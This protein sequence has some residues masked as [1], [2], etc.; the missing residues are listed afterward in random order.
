MVPVCTRFL[1]LTAILLVL[2]TTS[3]FT[4]PSTTSSLQQRSTIIAL[5]TNPRPQQLQR[6]YSSPESTNKNDDILDYS[7]LP[8]KFV[9]ILAVK[10][11]KDLVN[12][13]P[14]LLEE[15]LKETSEKNETNPLVLLAKLMGVLVFKL[16]HDATHYPIVWSKRWAE[17]QSLEECPVDYPEDE[18]NN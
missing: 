7:L 17:C 5:T 14:L 10:T 8:F 3:A 4:L 12:Y 2:A 13:P 11:L 18:E 15:L 16:F 1:L 9:G 6:L